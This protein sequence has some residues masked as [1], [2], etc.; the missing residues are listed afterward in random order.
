MR[1][2]P[3]GPLPPTA[4][5]LLRSIATELRERFL[6][7]LFLETIVDSKAARIDEKRRRLLQAE[8]STNRRGLRQARGEMER[9][10]YSVVSLD[11]LVV[12]VRA[13]AR[14]FGR[15]IE[16]GT[17]LPHVHFVEKPDS[18]VA[19]ADATRMGE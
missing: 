4:L 17:P 8:L 6:W 18:M 7:I 15:L 12:R 2:D 13:S 3:E 5:P 9:A 10:G 11:H 16:L 14:P 1:T 19:R